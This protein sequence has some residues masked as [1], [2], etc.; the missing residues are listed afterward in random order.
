M[1]DYPEVGE[2]FTSDFRKRFFLY[3]GQQCRQEQSNVT[4]WTWARRKDYDGG[5]LRPSCRVLGSTWGLGLKHLID[6]SFIGNQ[7]DVL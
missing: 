1:S 7:P 5:T 3:S 6:V 2:S 4:W